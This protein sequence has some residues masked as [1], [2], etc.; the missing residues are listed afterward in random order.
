M[1]SLAVDR[2]RLRLL[3]RERSGKHGKKVFGSD[4]KLIPRMFAIR[5]DV[6]K[7]APIATMS[8]SG[9]S[10]VGS[11]VCDSQHQENA[12]HKEVS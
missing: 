12:Y 6:F 8:E 2:F 1:T 4:L 3:K 9:Q 10:G 11:G 5:T 7:Q